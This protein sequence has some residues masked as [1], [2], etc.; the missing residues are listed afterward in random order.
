MFSALSEQLRLPRNTV[1]HYLSVLHELGFV[2]QSPGDQ[3]YRLSPKRCLLGRAAPLDALVRD[4]ARPHLR[5]LTEMMGGTTILTI[6]DGAM[7]LHVEKIESPHAMRLTA[8]IGE[9]V[10]LHCGSS[11]RCLL[12]YL[13]ETEREAYLVRPLLSFSP[14]TITDPGLLRRAIAETRYGVRR[15]ALGNR[16]QDDQHCRADLGQLRQRDRRHQ[17][18]RR[19]M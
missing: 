3:R 12:A 4:A 6:A 16:R 8:W 14:D 7:A 11:P 5:A 9:R 15:L 13:P 19:L 1:A 17:H 18:G 10:P 2:Q